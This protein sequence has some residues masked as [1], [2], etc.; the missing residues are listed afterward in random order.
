MTYSRSESLTEELLVG[1][2]SSIPRWRFARKLEGRGEE[3]ITR[4]VPDAM[5][6]FLRSSSE[7][8]TGLNTV[9][10][11]LINRETSA[12]RIKLKLYAALTRSILYLEKKDS[13][14]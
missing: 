9:V 1:S 10:E 5:D 6:A 12:P 13:R 4:R 2:L 7:I 14:Y 11:F 8:I 3:P